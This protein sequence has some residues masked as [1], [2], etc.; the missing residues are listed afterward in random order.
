MPRTFKLMLV[1]KWNGEIETNKLYH[2]GYAD[3]N[4][5]VNKRE[6]V[7]HSL[8]WHKNTL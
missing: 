1:S 6:I 8:N 3:K 2:E 7:S 4:V 5:T